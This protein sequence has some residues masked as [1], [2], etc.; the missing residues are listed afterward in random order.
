M[1]CNNSFLFSTSDPQWSRKCSSSSTSSSHC[2]HFLSSLF[3]LFHLPVST[4][5]PAVPPLNYTRTCCRFFLFPHTLLCNLTPLIFPSFA[6]LSISLLLPPTPV[7]PLAPHSQSAYS[8]P[9][10]S[11]SSSNLKIPYQKSMHLFLAS[12]SY[13]S[14]PIS[15]SKETFGLSL[16]TPRN[17]L[18]ALNCTCSTASNFLPQPHTSAPYSS[19]DCT[20]ASVSLIKVSPLTYPTLILHLLSQAATALEP[21]VALSSNITLYPWCSVRLH[22][23]YL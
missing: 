14:I 20:S 17:I 2:L 12:H 7:S 19:T 16:L 21:A 3:S 23:S 13:G 15:N 9:P 8:S 10:P 4:F 1:S 18:S 22:P 5:S 11:L 6:A